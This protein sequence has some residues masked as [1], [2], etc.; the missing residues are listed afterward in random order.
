MKINL[1]EKDI[2]TLITQIEARHSKEILS[3]GNESWPITRIS[4]IKILSSKDKQKENKKNLKKRLSLFIR[5][6][7]F[8]K[9]QIFQSYYFFN[10]EVLKSKNIF[11]SR[12]HFLDKLNSG[13]FFDRII[14]P[15]Y[16]TSS[17]NV[18]S[19]KFYLDENF[20][21]EKLFANGFL[22]QRNK[23][24][25]YMPKF[26]N[27][28]EKK[29][30]YECSYFM[31]LFVKQN[32]LGDIN[33]LL[34]K[35]VKNAVKRYLHSKYNAKT[36]LK[37]FQDLKNIYISAWYAPDAMGLIAAANQLGIKTTEIQHGKQGKYQPAYS[38]WNFIPK[39]GFLNLPKFFWCWGQKSFDNI[40]GENKN[41]IHHRPILVSYPWPIWFETFISKKVTKNNEAKIKLLFT[42]QYTK[43]NT[44]QEPLKDGLL[45]L[46]KKYN[47]NNQLSNKE[48]F[49]LRIRIHPQKIKESIKYL[50][51]RLGD[52]Y[53]SKIVSY[54]SSLDYCLYE[55]LIWA[56]HHLTNFS[57]CAIESLNFNLKSAVYGNLASEIYEEEINN[58][59]LIHLNNCSIEELLDWIKNK[60]QVANVNTTKYISNKFLDPDI[61][62]DEYE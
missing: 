49:H 38:G 17:A 34:Q 29:L 52:L 24:L 16:L 12:S 5:K 8:I 45:E 43:G 14:D 41:K 50:K 2:F 54:S 15:F 44:I 3:F 30:E 31:G 25:M 51:K 7:W 27:K 4:I 9:T 33:Q 1:D 36:F 60:K 62:S 11:F 18:R 6:L 56:N 40:L 28:E 55:D 37:K 35:D 46:I 59:S 13:K 21:R 10:K 58:N 57:S 19:S 39:N 32:D 42:M 20:F 61:F 48:E 23:I 26:S 47:I 53:Y 22:Y